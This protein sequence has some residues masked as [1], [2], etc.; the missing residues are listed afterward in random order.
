MRKNLLWFNVKSYAFLCIISIFYL[1]FKVG[2]PIG[3]ATASG[4]EPYVQFDYLLFLVGYC[5]LW[6]IS[7]CLLEEGELVSGKGCLVMGI[8]TFISISVYWISLLH[9]RFADIQKGFPE[10]GRINDIVAIIVYPAVLFII[11]LIICIIYIICA[12]QIRKEN[13]ALG[14]KT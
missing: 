3:I 14:W 10:P 8:F 9:N 2:Y 5:V 13:K 12:V 7:R 11:S 4:N 1:G 6:L